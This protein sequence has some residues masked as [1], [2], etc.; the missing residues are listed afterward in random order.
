MDWGRVGENLLSNLPNYLIGGFGVA[1]FVQWRKDRRAAARA[2]RR[3]DAMTPPQA[4]DAPPVQPLAK[5]RDLPLRHRLGL[6]FVNWLEFTGFGIYL[7]GAIV[8]VATVGGTAA[9][10]VTGS[11]WPR[12][13]VYALG[14]VG[15]LTAWMISLLSLGALMHAKE[16]AAQAAATCVQAKNPSRAARVVPIVFGAFVFLLCVAV[17][18]VGGAVMYNL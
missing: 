2:V 9:E 12:W 13:I 8:V 16:T 7:L 3:R 18:A 6:G 5:Y 1:M 10:A 17:L 14:W 15:I 11:R 4:S